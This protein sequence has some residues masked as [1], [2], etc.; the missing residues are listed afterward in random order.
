MESKE[1]LKNRIVLYPD[2]RLTTPCLAVDFAQM[3]MVQLG[4][5]GMEMIKILQAHEG[6]LGLA[7]NQAGYT[8]RIFVMRDPQNNTYKILINPEIIMRLGVRKSVEGCL[9]LPNVFCT[10][11]R[12]KFVV[13][14]YYDIGGKMRKEKLTKMLSAV[15]QHEIA[16]L[17]GKLMTDEEGLMNKGQ[18]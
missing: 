9:S 14:K 16:H 4:K 11:K 7:A 12:S 17:S 2:P 5:I 10:I 15:A 13:I 3:T 6:G 1:D 18:R 8:M